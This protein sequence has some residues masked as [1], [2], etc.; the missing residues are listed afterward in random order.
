[1]HN[2][3]DRGCEFPSTAYGAT[4]S[5]KV[6]AGVVRRSSFSLKWFA[7]LGSIAIFAHGATR[8]T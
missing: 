1:M 8:V 2:S 5:A 7:V 4:L 3:P 6:A